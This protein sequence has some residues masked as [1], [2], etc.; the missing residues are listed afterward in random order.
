MKKPKSGWKSPI[1]NRDS[2]IES[3]EK[4]RPLSPWASDEEY[5]RSQRSKLRK[6]ISISKTTRNHALFPDWASFSYQKEVQESQTIKSRVVK[7]M[8]AILLLISL[9]LTSGIV[10]LMVK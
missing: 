4:H 8:T 3:R 9:M 6:Q 7:V 2:D 5:R 10:C 1:V